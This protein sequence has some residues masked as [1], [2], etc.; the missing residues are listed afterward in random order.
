MWFGLKSHCVICSK[1]ICVLVHP[2]PSMGRVDAHKQFC[3]LSL[4][5]VQSLTAETSK[6]TVTCTDLR[7]GC[8]LNKKSCENCTY[9]N[10]VPSLV[11]I[12]W[13]PILFFSNNTFLCCHCPVFFLSHLSFLTRV[14]FMSFMS[15]APSLISPATAALFHFF[16]IQCYCCYL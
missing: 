1:V 5:H 10:V 2:T 3:V 11:I 7:W 4:L 8:W 16:L 9:A 13:F 12:L 15:C 14:F 6:A